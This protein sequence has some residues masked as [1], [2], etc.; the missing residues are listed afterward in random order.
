M[1]GVRTVRGGS[2]QCKGG[3]VACMSENGKVVSVAGGSQEREEKQDRRAQRGNG[4]WVPQGL[5]GTMGTLGLT[6][7]KWTGAA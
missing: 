1:P 6:P 2:S 5:A 3:S 7:R 4:R